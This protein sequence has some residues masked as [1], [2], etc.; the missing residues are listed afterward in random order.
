MPL[1]ND[2][3]L[4]N[5][6]KLKTNSEP[7]YDKLLWFN[8]DLYFPI[9]VFG[10]TKADLVA[11]FIETGKGVAIYTTEDKVYLSSETAILMLQASNNIHLPEFVALMVRLRQKARDVLP[12][13]PI[14]EELL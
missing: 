6:K 9:E 8:E 4:Q 7:P 10:I 5:V 12:I 2:Q 1:T 14:N 11:W 3:E 13:E